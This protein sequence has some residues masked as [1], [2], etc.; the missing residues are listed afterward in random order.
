MTSAD[1]Y[2]DTRSAISGKTLSETGAGAGNMSF[3]KFLGAPAYMASTVFLP[4][5]TAVNLSVSNTINIAFL[6]LAMHMT[7]LP[8]FI[9]AMWNIIV[10][11]H[12]H[13]YANPVP[14]YLLV[15]YVMYRGVQACSMVSTFDPRQSLPALILMLLMLP[16]AFERPFKR[17]VFV[18]L[19]T[20]SIVTLLA[21]NLVRM[22]SHGLL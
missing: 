9:I 16:F 3:A 10:S 4:V 2:F 11:T 14:L 1:S 5:F 20:I 12:E 15:S 17:K 6:P 7:L 18:L 8:F 22:K 13:A 19:I 21:I